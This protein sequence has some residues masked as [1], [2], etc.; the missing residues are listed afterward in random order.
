MICGECRCLKKGSPKDRVAACPSRGCDAVLCRAH[1]VLH[2]ERRGGG[3]YHDGST[4]HPARGAPRSVINTQ[5]TCSLSVLLQCLAAAMPSSL[6]IPAV[7]DLQRQGAHS[8]DCD[9][10]LL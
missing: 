3:G 5:S 10:R 1:L 9:G 7:S 2:N 4:D 6:A 8:K